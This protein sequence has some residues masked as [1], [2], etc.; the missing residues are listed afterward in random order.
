[1]YANEQY[2]VLLRLADPLN[3]EHCMF[4]TA[5]LNTNTEKNPKRAYPLVLREFNGSFQPL[6]MRGVC[7]GQ[8]SDETSMTSHTFGHLVKRDAPIACLFL[9]TIS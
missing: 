2:F 5:Y 9:K 8:M 3:K 4:S 6:E 7:V 1:M